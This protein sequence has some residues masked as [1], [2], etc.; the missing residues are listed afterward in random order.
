MRS[1][2]LPSAEPAGLPD[3]GEPA[4]LNPSEMKAQPLR[5][6]SVQAFSSVNPPR[7]P[8]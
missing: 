2:G 1:R 3:A 8:P 7:S 6:A 5:F 4:I